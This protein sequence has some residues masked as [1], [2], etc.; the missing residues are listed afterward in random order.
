MFSSAIVVLP[1]VLDNPLQ[2]LDP[3]LKHRNEHFL[4]DFTENSAYCAFEGLAVQKM[5]SSDLWFYE[6]KEKG[7]VQGQVWAIGP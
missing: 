6:T 5:D 7:V 4:V 1:D 2:P 3:I